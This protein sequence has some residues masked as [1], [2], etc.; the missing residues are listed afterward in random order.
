MVRQLPNV[1]EVILVNNQYFNHGDFLF[2]K[3]VTQEINN[4]VNQIL[5][6]ADNENWS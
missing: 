1:R 3:N 4:P 6:N 5:R 2:S